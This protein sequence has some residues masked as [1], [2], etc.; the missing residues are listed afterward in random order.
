MA[1]SKEELKE[2]VIPPEKE[3]QEVMKLVTI[4]TFIGSSFAFIFGREPGSLPEDIVKELAPSIIVVCGFLISYELF[5]VMGVGLAKGRHGILELSYKDLPVKDAEEIF[6][7][8]RV[9]TNQLEQMPLFITG[10]FL[11]SLLVNGQ[12]GGILSLAW[13]VLRRKYAVA[14][15]NGEGKKMKQIGIA[16][17]TIPCY[18][19]VNTM[20]VSSGIQALRGYLK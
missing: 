1:R 20:V 19:I 17:F 2:G 9:L 15:K 13:V 6:I 16:N 12:I 14:Y 4:F 11:F 10:T 18:F 7:R 5:D 3:F 8:Q